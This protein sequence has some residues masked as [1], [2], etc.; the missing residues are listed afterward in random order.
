MVRTAK[1]PCSSRAAQVRCTCS[2][3]GLKEQKT[4]SG[5]R[6]CAADATAYKV[7]NIDNFG[8]YT[9]NVGFS[10]AFWV[11]EVR[12]GKHMGSKS[13]VQRYA[14]HP[15]ELGC[16]LHS[17]TVEFRNR[18]LSTGSPLEQTLQP[19]SALNQLAQQPSL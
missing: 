15:H 12:N 6:H 3:H 19:C 1:K 18:G 7:H 11:L 4:P 16:Q 14:A 2:M 10:S 17:K 9:E 13:S 5:L 8:F